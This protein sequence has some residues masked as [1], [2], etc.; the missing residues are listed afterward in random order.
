MSSFSAGEFYS[1]NELHFILYCGACLQGHIVH[2][3]PH[4]E[5]DADGKKTA[6][7]VAKFTRVRRQRIGNS[8]DRQSWEAIKT[9]NLITL[10]IREQRS[11]W[12]IISFSGSW[13]SGGEMNA[14]VAMR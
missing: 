6:A 11:S 9:Y 5:F 14:Q 7:T 3:Q 13:G 1:R 2:L 4:L 8:G 10:F 12:E